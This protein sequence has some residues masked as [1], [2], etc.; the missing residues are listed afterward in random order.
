MLGNSNKRVST[1]KWYRT[2][3]RYVIEVIVEEVSDEFFDELNKTGTTGCDDIVQIID[4]ALS[5]FGLE[6]HSKLVKYTD[7]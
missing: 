7:D 3:K 6:G 4:N 2:M 5:P 1:I